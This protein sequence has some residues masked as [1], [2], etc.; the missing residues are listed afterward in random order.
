MK[1]LSNSNI[2]IVASNFD[3]SIFNLFWFVEQGIIAKDDID[4]KS[5]IFAPQ[6]VVLDTKKMMLQILPNHIICT[7]KDLSSATSYA[8]H[9]LIN[10]LNKAPAAPYQAMGVN[11]AWDLLGDENTD[12]WQ[13]TSFLFGLQEKSPLKAAFATSDSLF[14]YYASKNSNGFRLKLDIKPMRLPN[15]KD[16]AADP[17]HIIRCSF[18]YHYDLAF[19]QI[20]PQDIANSLIKDKWQCLFDESS[21][22]AASLEGGIQ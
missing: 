19:N 8:L 16:A 1:N 21:K 18:N 11:F 14:G 20:T 9:N 2:V 13:S 12:I 10:L 3:L 7:V 17:K 15:D 6:A 4:F 22:I 5:S